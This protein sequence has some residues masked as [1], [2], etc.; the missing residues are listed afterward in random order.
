MISFLIRE[1]APW[2]AILL[3]LLLERSTHKKLEQIDQ[4]IDLGNREKEIEKEPRLTHSAGRVECVLCTSPATG[5]HKSGQTPLCEDHLK[6]IGHRLWLLV[7][8][9]GDGLEPWPEMGTRPMRAS[10]TFF[11]DGIDGDGH[12]EFRRKA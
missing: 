1:V 10:G 11:N 5:F 2:V 8:V 12:I 6:M 4:V 9:E 3:L 7:A